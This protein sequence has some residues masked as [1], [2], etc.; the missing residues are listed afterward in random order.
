VFDW[1]S[2][3]AALL[4]GVPPVTPVK[5]PSASA[6]DSCPNL[7]VHPLNGLIF[8]TAPGKNTELIKAAGKIVDK[9]FK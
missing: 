2:K 5:E 7:I 9:F 8:D 3:A 4:K 6:A 1:V